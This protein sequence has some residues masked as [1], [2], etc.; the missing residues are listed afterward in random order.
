MK[1]HT[2]PHTYEHDTVPEGDV[3]SHKESLC[4]NLWFK[5][6][7]GSTCHSI[8]TARCYLPLGSGEKDLQQMDGLIQE[9]SGS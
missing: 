6:Q 1:K 8:E 4:D 9:G 3:G 5:L 2:D 7:L